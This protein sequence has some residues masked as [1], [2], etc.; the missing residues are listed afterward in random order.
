MCWG[1]E[2]AGEREREGEIRI[3]D[4]SKLQYNNNNK[5]WEAHFMFDRV[6]ALELSMTV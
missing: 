6:D 5:T 2:S 3:V 4:K 1:R